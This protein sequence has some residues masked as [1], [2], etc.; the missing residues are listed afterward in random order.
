MKN[1]KSHGKKVGGKVIP[2][3]LRLLCLNIEW[4]KRVNE[5]IK[6]SF[7][8]LAR[9]RGFLTVSHFD[10]AERRKFERKRKTARKQVKKCNQL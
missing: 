1:H 2:I 8:Y 9:S 6:S 7:P 4:K 10:W 3:S 5:N